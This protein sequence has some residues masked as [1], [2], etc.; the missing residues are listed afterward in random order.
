MYPFGGLP[1]NLASFCALLRHEY[2]FRIGTG[3]L[4]DAA[5]ALTIIDLTDQESVRAAL[6]TVLAGTRDDVTAFDA[7]FDRFFLSRPVAPVHE[8]QSAPGE[9]EAGLGEEEDQA[10]V[11]KSAV[12]SPAE[13]RAEV[14]A[15]K[16]GPMIPLETS[17]E[18]EE[19]AVSARASY[20]PVA[21]ESS[22]APEVGDVDEGWVD[23]ARTLVRRMQLGPSRK[24]RAAPK[25]RRF[26]VRRTLRASVQTG[27]ELL[28]PRWRARPKKQP[29][30][31]VLIDGSRSM[32]Q[33]AGT[34]LTMAAALARAT[35]RLEVFTFSTALQRVTTDVQLASTGRPRR[36]R[37][38][39]YAWGGGTTIG[40]CLAE[41]LR[42][43]GE[44]LLSRHAV[45]IVASDGLDVGE[46]DTLRAAMQ[47]LR[48]RSAAVVWLNP[49]LDTPGYE[50]T[51]LGM[52]IARP[53]ATTLSSVNDLADFV[54][55]SR[56][57]RVGS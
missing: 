48:R 38:L 41:F 6:R 22:G 34:A 9:L 52:S 31:I 32:S 42:R 24:W 19:H 1:E 15:E 3:E 33:Y 10:S 43:F 28:A 50:P 7:A 40:A 51:A 37:P 17:D 14:P 8:T 21:V 46:P 4:L 23:A 45:V 56:T 44:R 30:F 47:A 12:G 36:F 39:A 35:S 5:R 55:L 18:E 26:D 27:G 2:G 49:L 53:F 20:S 16:I 29:R 11:R 25:G 13:D 54:R 57:L